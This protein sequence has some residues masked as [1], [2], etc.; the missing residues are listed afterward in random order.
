MFHVKQFD[1]DIIVVGGGHA[2]VEAA[3]A[4]ARM[5]AKVLLCTANIEFIGQMSCNPS[6]G[7]LAKGNLVKDLDALGGE[8]AK[9]IDSSAIQYRILNTKKGPAVR[10]T[11]AQADKKIYREE[12]LN[13]LLND[14]RIDIKQS[15]VTNLLIVGNNIYGIETNTGQ[16]F[17]APVVILT[18]GTFL[19]GLIHIG[20][21]TYRGGRAN[22]FSSDEL[23]LCL[24]KIGL[25]MGR[26]KTGTPA[27]LDKRSIKFHELT[28]QWGDKDVEYFS[29]ETEAIK[30]KQ[31][32]CYLTYTNKETHK[33][34]Y[35]NLQKS[36]LYG[37]YITG[38]GPRYCPSIEDKVVKFSDKERHQVFLEPEGID[39][40]EIYANGLST[41][42]PVDIQIKFYRTI[43]GLE[44]VEFLRPAYAI[45]Y[46]YINPTE[47]YPTLESK[48]INGLYLAGQING[49]TGYEEAA[50]LGFMAGVNAVLKLNKFDPLILKRDQSYIG[51][52]IDDLVTKGVDEPYR[53][54]HSRGE[55]RLILRED[56]AEFRLLEIGYK[57]GLIK[58]SRY[59]RFLEERKIFNEEVTRLKNTLIDAKTLGIDKYEKFKAYDLLKRPEIKYDTIKNIIGGIENTKVEREVEIAIKYE[60]YM[61][62]LYEDLKLYEKIDRIYIPNTLN[63]K[64]ISGL[65]RE[66]IEKL[67]KIKPVTLGQAARIPGMTPAAISLLH[68]YIGNKS[69]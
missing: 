23:S 57:L 20:D 52:M 31:V 55:Y 8:M 56:N 26:L 45:E 25:D 61:R 59:D 21:K 51:V 69:V 4:T 15:I 43:K 29:F 6:I 22:E 50:A 58:K 17:K 7:G 63:Y 19:N 30:Q 41:S 36:A 27:R 64:N 32:P 1:Y 49:T 48:K 54:F 2:G 66:F 24:K 39:S 13:R 35:D 28:E 65:R 16:T 60:G 67:E 40:I 18:V 37:G 68:I 47:L 11:R 38:I 5:Q 3:L 10:S 33:I 46:D 44:N 42:L 14:D 12:A 34:I 53:M 62:K 9:I